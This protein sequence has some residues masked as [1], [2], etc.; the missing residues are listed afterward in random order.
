MS[1][2]Y[3]PPAREVFET[4]RRS[5]KARAAKSKEKP[6]VSNSSSV[7]DPVKEMEGTESYFGKLRQT[8]QSFRNNQ[9]SDSGRYIFISSS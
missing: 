9:S 8:R 6:K 3:G 1:T 2:E 7:P 5:R 4:Q